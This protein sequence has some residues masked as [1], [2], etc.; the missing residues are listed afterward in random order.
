MLTKRNDASGRFETDL[1]LESRVAEG[2]DSSDKGGAERSQPLHAS[3]PR[4]ARRRNK[5]C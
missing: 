3:Q 1:L 2:V 4:R 5:P